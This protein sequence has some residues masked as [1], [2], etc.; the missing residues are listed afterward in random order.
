MAA[1]TPLS[2]VD[3]ERVADAFGLGRCAAVDAITAGCMNSNYRLDTDR[4]RYVVRLYERQGMDE[5]EAEWALLDHFVAA[6]AR[7]PRRC[8]GPALRVGGRP[9]GV[10]E[11]VE[12][13]ERG[14]DAIDAAGLARLGAIVGE[15]HAI[16]DGIAFDR[17][18]HYSP[19]ALGARVDAIERVHRPH[20]IETM[21]TVEIQKVNLRVQ[22]HPLAGPSPRDGGQGVFHELMSPPLPPLPP[23]PPPS[24]STSPSPL[25]SRS[26]PAPP[27]R[28]PPPW[29][30]S[31]P[32]S[33]CRTP[34]A[35]DL[36]ATR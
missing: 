35:A 20:R 32:R 19:A 8:A 1:F 2:P 26:A 18:D 24:P 34:G 14:A 22:V 10:F 21:A 28:R 30:P 15:L 29:R 12:G 5:I 13:G 9:V 3:A 17:V 36:A 11:W 27:P 16:G 25:P 4:G 33:C 7:V 23:P 31:P 6:G